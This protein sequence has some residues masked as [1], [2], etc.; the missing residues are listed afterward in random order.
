MRINNDTINFLTDTID[1]IVTHYYNYQNNL[2]VENISETVENKIHVT[3]LEAL[4][5]VLEMYM[6]DCEIEVDDKN[7]QIVNEL[8]EQLDEWFANHTVNS[9]EIRRA[10]LLLN[11]KG[12]KQSNYSLDIITPDAVGMVL[13]HLVNAYFN[14]GEKISILDPNCGTGNLMSL[15]NNY[16]PNEVEFVGIDNHQILT[17]LC[18]AEANFL[19]MQAQIYYQDALQDC[20]NNHD[21]LVTDV[22][23]YD[24]DLK[25][26]KSELGDKGIKY[27]PYL[28]IEKYLSSKN[29]INKQIYLIDNDFFEQEGSEI[30][31][32]YL[33]DKAIIKSLIALPKSMFLKEDYT[34]GILIL[35]SKDE[36]NKNQK[37]GVYI[38]P[39]LSETEKLNKVL[40]EI[41]KDL[42]N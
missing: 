20:F 40:N 12:F 28:L 22:A 38:L 42:K 4:R 10:L 9:E 34:R 3:Y 2:N 8:F 16:L 27:F 1:E 39:S 31:K 13:V 6:D 11:I 36:V 32:D 14:E 17:T 24:Y 21:I 23:S 18:S 7:Q 33:Q 25:N 19:E 5:D 29:S 26:Y 15:L 35:E 37:T 41:K 30:F